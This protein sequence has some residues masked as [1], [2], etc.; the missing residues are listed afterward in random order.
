M[1][2]PDEP[3]FRLFSPK[4]N[5]TSCFKGGIKSTVNNNLILGK[6]LW[7]QLVK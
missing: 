6:I 3:V 7:L 1:Q 2:E 5:H 4:K